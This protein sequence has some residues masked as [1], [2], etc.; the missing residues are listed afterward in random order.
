MERA[1]AVA[2]RFVES[3]FDA[4]QPIDGMVS[5]G[6][7]FHAW[8]SVGTGA[9]GLSAARCALARGWVDQVVDVH[10]TLQADDRVILR[11]TE[12]GVHAGAW[13]GVPPTGRDVGAAAI[14]IVRVVDGLVVEHWRETDDLTRLQQVR[15]PDPATAEPETNR[16]TT[17]MQG[18]RT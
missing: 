1:R 15:P 5:S 17:S 9:A 2:R 4:D 6:A 3:L 16:T 10:E 13:H 8:P 7:V 14:H 12:R 18:L 11:V